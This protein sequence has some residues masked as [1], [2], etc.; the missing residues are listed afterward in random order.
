MTH[1]PLR[2]IAEP[3]TLDLDLLSQRVRIE[4]LE[5]SWLEALALGFEPSPRHP[6]TAHIRLHIQLHP[7][8][9]EAEHLWWDAMTDPT[10]ALDDLPIPAP[11][12]PAHL[13]S[14]LNLWAVRE[15]DQHYV[16]HAAAVARGG[17]GVL[18]PAAS[19]R[20]KSTLTAALVRLGFDLLSDEVG[21]VELGSGTLVGYPRAMSLRRDVFPL[22]GLDESAGASLGDGDAQMVRVGAIGG[23]RASASAELRLIMLPRFLADHDTGWQ[24]LRPGPAAM[25]LLEASCSQHRFK[26]TGLDFVLDL[27]ERLPCYELTYSDLDQAVAMVAALVAEVDR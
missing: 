11:R 27:A 8:E 14:A 10:D 13:V 24:R 21:A 6:S 19:R 22:L 9:Q 16:F 20:G 3:A 5:P 15:T 7:P 2:P 17:V 23:T 12:T 18:L 25:R 4:A 26:E 1:R